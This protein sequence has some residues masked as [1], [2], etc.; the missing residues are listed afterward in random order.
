MYSGTMPLRIA[1][2]GILAVYPRWSRS[3]AASFQTFI[4][5]YILN[6]QW[7]STSLIAE[8]EYSQ[9]DVRGHSGADTCRALTA[10]GRNRA[11]LGE[12]WAIL[13]MS[14]HM[15]RQGGDACGSTMALGIGHRVFFSL[16][17]LAVA[18]G[19]KIRSIYIFWPKHLQNIFMSTYNGINER[20]YR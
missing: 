7:M 5:E 6:A 3:G 9:L 8:T 17:P 20:I 12:P 4:Y 2:L 16:L 10:S 1:H 11:P 18:M 13:A 19:P 15:S 14:A